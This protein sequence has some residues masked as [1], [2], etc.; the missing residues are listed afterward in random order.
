MKYSFIFL[1]VWCVATAGNTQQ[2]SGI[3]TRW[4][5]SFVAWEILAFADQETETEADDEREEVPAG[6]FSQRWA[7]VKD[8]WSEWDYEVLEERGT[9]RAKWKD[10]PTQWELR[11][12]DGHIITMRTAW[13][14]DMNEWR[15]TDNDVALTLRSRWTNQKDEWLVEDKNRGRFY[16]YTLRSGDPRDW[17]IED[18]LNDEVSNALKTAIVFLTVFNSSPRQ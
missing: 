13:G 4:N 14:K 1:M 5:D 9:I 10:D 8:D 12:Y 15:I 6:E 18:G 7:Q 11:S 2:L 3:S 17:A 16:M